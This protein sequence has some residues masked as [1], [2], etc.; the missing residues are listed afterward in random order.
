MGIPV[1]GDVSIVFFQV[2]G[3]GFLITPGHYLM[4]V[5]QKY[6][7]EA[8]LNSFGLRKQLGDFLGKKIRYVVKLA[9]HRMKIG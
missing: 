6:F 7:P 3:K 5:D 4:A 9:F 2:D 1:D 8:Y